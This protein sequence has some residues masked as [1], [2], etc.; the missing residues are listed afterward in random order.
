MCNKDNKIYTNFKMLTALLI[1]PLIGSF[2]LLPIAEG[3][4]AGE[5]RMKRIA[6]ATAMVNFIVSIVLWGEFDSSA[7]QY[8]FVQEFNNLSF[9]HFHIGVDGISLYFILLTTFITPIC[10][11]SNWDTIKLGMKYFLIAFLLLETL[12]I[13]VFVVLDLML[14]YIFFESVLIPLF[15]I[16]GIWGGSDTRIRASFLLFLY[17]L[18]GSLFMLLGIM[19][20]Y[21]NIGSTDFTMISLSDISLDSQKL[22]W[23]AFFLSFAIKTPLVPFHMWLPRAHAEA[24]LAG[25]ILLAGLILKLATYGY[26]RVLI[27]FMPDATSYFSPL[28]QTIAVVTLIY[29]SLATVRQVDFKALVAYSSIGHMAVVVLGLFSN[30]IIGIEGAIALSIAHGVISPA[31][32]ILVGGVLYDRFHTRVIRYYRGVTV[33]MPVFSALFF[34]TT[35]FNMAVPLSLNWIGE[36]MSLAGV[37]QKSPLVG[38]LG[39]SSIILSAVYS[40]YLYNRISFGAYSRYLSYTTDITRREFM[41]LFPLLLVAVIFGIMPNIILADL[42]V[43][44]SGLLYTTA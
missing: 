14:F 23:L 16:V 26:L 34:V 31:M 20:I 18:G 41:L 39:A 9:C 27:N 33:Y 11:L 8:Q 6:L 12:L 25:S 36:F 22:L 32:F 44:V 19:V 29:S 1:I 4:V 2:A 15:L 40:I 30:T 10:I 43:A 42:H 17:T 24:P 7:S 35:A 38:L 37:F 5:S 3:S 13:A 28:V 21:Y